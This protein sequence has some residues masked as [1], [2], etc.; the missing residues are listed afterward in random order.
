MIPSVSFLA[1]QFEMKKRADLDKRIL[2]SKSG[3]ID[4]NKL[5]SYRFDDN[6][7]GKIT[8][9]PKG[10]KHGLVFFLD[11]SGSM[12]GK[13]TNTMK[14]LFLLI[15]FCQKVRIPFEVYA[16]TETERFNGMICPDPEDVMTME[17]GYFTF[18]TNLKL[19]NVLSSKM[20][21]VDLD[22]AQ[23]LLLGFSLESDYFP[24]EFQLSNTPLVSALSV[25]SG[26]ISDFR[27]ENRLQFVN[28]I[29]LT[30]GHSNSS[31][32]VLLDSGKWKSF[33]VGNKNRS[34]I[35]QD[36]VTKLEYIFEAPPV[37]FSEIAL[38]GLMVSIIRDR[39]QS[40]LMGFH[41]THQ[42]DEWME[43]YIGDDG[44]A[45]REKFHRDKFIGTENFGGFG[46]YF[47]IPSDLEMGAAKLEIESWWGD[48]A[49]EK[50]F[51]EHSR[52][53]VVNRVL[54]GRFIEQFA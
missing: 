54:F 45:V 37:V 24:D 46:D 23:K 43:Y 17:E 36:Q 4:V 34:V 12:Y 13:L 19:M 44:L 8:S 1:Q 16:F 49:K 51:L 48:E 7:F 50:A 30:D 52:A 33:G 25:A 9:I 22:F 15:N 5:H 31:R 26:L 32:G 27:K 20:R 42:L 28:T 41:V 6:I 21:P 2:T 47:F 3:V 40:V 29:F 38:F 53:K 14:Q 35:F 39:T 10:K 11:W 18:N